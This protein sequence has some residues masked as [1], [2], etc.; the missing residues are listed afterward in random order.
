VHFDADVFDALEM[1]AVTYAQPG[2][3]D[4]GQLE[5]LLRPPALLSSARRPPDS[6]DFEP[7]NDPDGH[8]ARRIDDLFAGLLEQ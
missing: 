6:R 8:N 5:A 4:R 1:P 3:L 2:G 7:D